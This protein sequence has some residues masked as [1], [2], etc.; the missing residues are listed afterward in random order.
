M[1]THRCACAKGVVVPSPL[2][3]DGRRAGS[4]H[5]ERGSFAVNDWDGLTREGDFDQTENRLLVPAL[6]GPFLP[7][8]PSGTQSS[9]AIG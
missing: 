8:P 6:G 9:L 3:A 2:P 1:R 4:L 7:A 5:E